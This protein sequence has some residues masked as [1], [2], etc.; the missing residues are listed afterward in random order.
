M[1]KLVEMTRALAREEDG[2]SLAEYLVL[3]GVL[4]VAV[5]GGVTLFGNT[6]GSLFSGWSTWLGS[7]AAA[8]A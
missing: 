6:M 5:V 2:A 1:S 3:L 8:P 7:H 4:T